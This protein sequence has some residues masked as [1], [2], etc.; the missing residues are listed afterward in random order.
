MAS[1]SGMSGLHHRI[2]TQRIVPSAAHGQEQII[3]AGK[4]DS[5]HHISA[6]NTAHNQPRPLVDHPVLDLASFFITRICGF[7]QV[8]AQVVPKTGNG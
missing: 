1:Y 6:I 4:V 5:R 7:D 8:T 2:P 3:L